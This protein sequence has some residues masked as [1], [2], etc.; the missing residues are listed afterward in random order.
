[1]RKE[2]E[3]KRRE[4]GGNVGASPKMVFP[5]PLIPSQVHEARR[6]VDGI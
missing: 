4:T 3:V 5:F 1:M 6:R 2:N